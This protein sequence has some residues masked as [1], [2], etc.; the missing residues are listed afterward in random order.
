MEVQTILND[1][2]FIEHNGYKYYCDV[3]VIRAITEYLEIQKP[4]QS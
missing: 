3:D 2:P 1:L 4:L